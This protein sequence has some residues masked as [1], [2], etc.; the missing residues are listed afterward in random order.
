MIQATQE[1][2]RQL[3]VTA[4]ETLDRQLMEQ[5]DRQSG[6]RRFLLG[7]YWDG[8][9]AA[10]FAP[11]AGRIQLCTQAPYAAAMDW[12]EQVTCGAVRLGAMPLWADVQADG[13]RADHETEAQ[14]EAGLERGDVPMVSRP[15]ATVNLEFDKLWVRGWRRGPVD[16]VIRRTLQDFDIL[17][18]LALLQGTPC[19]P[20]RL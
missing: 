19:R 18:V 11:G 7:R 15:A 1:A 5:Q 2:G 17:P 10:V 16:A 14:R 3:M 6:T 20:G 8:A 9:A 12:L 13:A 4:L